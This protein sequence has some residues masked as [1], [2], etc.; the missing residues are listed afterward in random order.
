MTCI[1]TWEYRSGG[2]HFGVRLPSDPLNPYAFARL[3]E[4]LSFLHDRFFSEAYASW[5]DS[6]AKDAQAGYIA[7]AFEVCEY[8]IPLGETAIEVNALIH[9]GEE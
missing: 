7:Q 6:V 9:G 2:V 1:G 8:V 5:R 4:E 3:A